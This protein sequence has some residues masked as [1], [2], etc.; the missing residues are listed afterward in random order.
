MAEAAWD[1]A[2]WASAQ[3]QT[4]QSSQP[5]AVTL[6]PRQHAVCDVAAQRAYRANKGFP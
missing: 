3:G 5:S 4:E 2:E 6:G 1:R